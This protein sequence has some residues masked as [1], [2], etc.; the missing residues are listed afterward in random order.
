MSESFVVL[1]EWSVTDLKLAE[2]FYSALFGWEFS[3][4]PGH[5]DYLQ[6]KA[7]EGV[8][9]GLQLEKKVEPASSPVIYIHV[10]DIDATLEKAVEMGGEIVVWKG[11]IPDGGFLAQLRDPFG[12]FV[13][14]YEE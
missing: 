8:L 10:K 6:F 7:A 12:N 5:D 14:L 13:G 2:E 3:E 4:W 1:I 11:M 9:G